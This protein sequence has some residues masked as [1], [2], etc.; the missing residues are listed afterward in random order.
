MEEEERG[1]RDCR[2]LILDFGTGKEEG[3]REVGG[4]VMNGSK[5]RFE[6]L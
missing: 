2:L 1:G 3:Q 5:G 6:T 4:R